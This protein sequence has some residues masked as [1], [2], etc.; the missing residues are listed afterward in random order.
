MD[1]RSQIARLETKIDDV[2]IT[3]LK[4]QRAI[5]SSAINPTKVDTSRVSVNFFSMFPLTT[6]ESVMK[7]EEDLTDIAF[8]QSVVSIDNSFVEIKMS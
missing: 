6:I 5:I 8:R 7:F 4:I 3:M 1:L 2:I